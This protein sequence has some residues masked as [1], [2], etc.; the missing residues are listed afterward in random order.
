LASNRIGGIHGRFTA[1]AG[2]SAGCVVGNVVTASYAAGAISGKATFESSAS[3]TAATATTAQPP[4]HRA[5]RIARP[6]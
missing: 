6:R 3:A 5:Q 4:H 1:G 2:S